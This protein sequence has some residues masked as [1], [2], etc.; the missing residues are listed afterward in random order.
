M[1]G[2]NKKGTNMGRRMIIKYEMQEFWCF[3]IP[4]LFKTIMSKM[5]IQKCY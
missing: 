5:S 2:L 1:F 3:Q 4:V